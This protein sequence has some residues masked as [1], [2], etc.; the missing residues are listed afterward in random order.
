MFTTARNFLLAGLMLLLVACVQSEAAPA[1]LQIVDAWARPAQRAVAEQ[2]AASAMTHTMMMTDAQPMTKSMDATMG[3]GM[4]GATSA[5]YLTI[6]NPGSQPDRLVK[7]ASPVA[8]AV[9]LHTVVEQNGM[10]TMH[11]VDGVDVPAHGEAILKPG[12]FHIMLIGLT[13][14]L[15]VGDTLTVTLTFAKAGEMTVQAQVR[16]R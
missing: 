12:S 15:K 2:P 6:R 5:A 16:E 7:V 1:G 8:K 11:P 14:A 10:M 13:C 9:E 3:K 4:G